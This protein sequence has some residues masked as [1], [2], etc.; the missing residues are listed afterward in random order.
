MVVTSALMNLGRIGIS[1]S[2]YAQSCSSLLFNSSTRMLGGLANL[3][4]CFW[5]YGKSCG[6]SCKEL[7]HLRLHY[8]STWCIFASNQWILLTFLRLFQKLY[9]HVNKVHETSKISINS[10]LDG[11]L[12][13]FALNETRHLWPHE[14]F[15]RN[16]I[17][18][19]SAALPTS[20]YL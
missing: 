12:S 10:A 9:F 17:H 5:P 4:Y 15:W 6:G 13:C 1:C 14:D 11:W 7:S 16:M 2:F 3:W 19:P 20:K 8:H 18:K